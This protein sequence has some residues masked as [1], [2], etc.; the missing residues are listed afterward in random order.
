MDK[1]ATDMKSIY[2]EMSQRNINIT[3]LRYKYI[4]I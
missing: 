2:K 4:N 1:S 3:Y